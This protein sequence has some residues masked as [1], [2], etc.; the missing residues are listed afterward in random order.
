MNPNDTPSPSPHI[1]PWRLHEQLGAGGLATVWRATNQAGQVAALKLM[2]I[3]G[4]D[5]EQL[6]RAQRE[7]AVLGGLH[8]PNIVSLLDSGVWQGRPWLALELVEGPDLEELLRQWAERPPKDRAAEATRIVRALASALAHVHRQGVTHR[9]IKPS[10]I[11]I[12]ADGNPKLADFGSVKAPEAFAT[13]LT[14]AGRIVGTVAFMAPE[15]ITGEPVDARTD[16]YALGA[17]LYL[18]LTGRRPVIAESI[19]GYLT[20]HL[21]EDPPPPV[22]LV[23]ELPL[24]LSRVAMRLLRKDPN[25]RFPSADAL[26]EALDAHGARRT[27]LHGRREAL[28]RAEE[29]LARLAQG[30]SGALPVVGPP[31]SG[32][33]ALL[34]EI[35]ARA[36]DDDLPVAAVSLNDEG[37]PSAVE[38]LHQLLRGGGHGV[39]MVDDLDAASPGAVRA[40]GEALRQ[41]PPKSA[42]LLVYSVRGDPTAPAST[43]SLLHHLSLH[44]TP[45][46][47]GGALILGPLEEAA[48]VAIC[49]D[50]ELPGAVAAAM[51]RRLAS[52]EATPAEAIEQL[53][54][55]EEQGWI[56]RDAAGLKR[57]AVP[58]E[59]LREGPLPLPARSRARAIE[60]IKRL[61]MHERA[62]VEALAVLGVEAERSLV[63]GLSDAQSPAGESELIEVRVEPLHEV[64]R[65]RQPELRDVIL[66]LIEPSRRAVLHERAARALLA[67]HQRRRASIAAVAAEHLTLA[68]R[69]AEAWP[70]WVTAA[71]RAARQGDMKEALAAAQRAVTQS[72]RADEGERA[73]PMRQQALAV[74]GEALLALRRSEEARD[75]FQRALDL[76]PGGP[77]RAEL[78][79]RLGMALGDLGDARAALPLLE[80]ALTSLDVGSPVRFPT[81]RAVADAQ[82]ALGQI[83]RARAT[84]EDA[85]TAARREQSPLREGSA[86]LGL[87]ELEMVLGHHDEAATALRQAERILRIEG[88]PRPLALALCLL[89]ELGLRAERHGSA[90]GR[91]AEAVHL[92]REHSMPDVLGQ[93]LVYQATALHRLNESPR[94]RELVSEALATEVSREDLPDRPLALLRELA[95]KLL[96]AEV[97]EGLRAPRAR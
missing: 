2:H 26:I 17:V 18:L 87:G 89:A 91:A 52:S 65:L 10:N 42:L 44:T 69:D 88:S 40:L 50:L 77:L 92:A 71:Q 43:L 46:A 94:A 62:M 66:A 23:P 93:A 21:L 54:A 32:R 67:R 24:H 86:L 55:L 31:G 11:L 3:D 60:R 12:A 34:T 6:T 49:R 85:L 83:T 63:E 30:Q 68:G 41:L 80:G 9:D 5:D 58:M 36:H 73:L 15:Q 64:L 28:A 82:L 45:D 39:L 27:L 75:T 1:G 22:E 84:W 78:S 61:T 8:H 57:L 74:A 4:L 38:A 56:T 59:R 95:G 14:M 96:G 90:E 70:L 79:A 25:L 29:A 72:E 13:H 76:V 53:Q 97:V 7:L 47:E 48:L 16:L 51:G 37:G 33:S 35:G 19:A 20:K 81:L